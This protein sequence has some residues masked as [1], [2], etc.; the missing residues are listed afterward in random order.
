MPTV[1]DRAAPRRPDK[2]GLAPG[3]I[4]SAVSAQ[5]DAPAS[6]H[7]IGKIDDRG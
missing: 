2:L 5:V 7:H 4:L 1:A 6:R 3:A